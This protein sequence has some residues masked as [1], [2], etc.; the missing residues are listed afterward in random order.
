MKLWSFWSRG[1]TKLLIHKQ[2][3]I[4]WKP[5]KTEIVTMEELKD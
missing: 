3:V 4:S 1:L 2:V 5:Y